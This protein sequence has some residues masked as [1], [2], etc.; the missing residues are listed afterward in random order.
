MQLLHC[1][2]FQIGVIP[3]YHHLLHWRMSWTWHMLDVTHSI[4]CQ[5][6]ALHMLYGGT[7]DTVIPLRA[8]S[9]PSSPWLW[10]RLFVSCSLFP[11]LYLCLCLS[12]CVSLFLS[13]LLWLLVPMVTGL[14][15]VLFCF[16]GNW[17][18]VGILLSDLC[19][20]SLMYVCMCLCV[21]VCLPAC[22]SVCVCHCKMN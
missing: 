17:P 7:V 2:V 12:V 10:L 9:S 1:M 13:L 22:V 11:S 14:R 5:H 21:Y 19:V 20:L 6:V 4:C 15:C 18:T 3:T 8:V 16:Y